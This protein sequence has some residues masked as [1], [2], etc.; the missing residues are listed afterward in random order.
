M[1]R[2]F[3]FA[4][5]KETEVVLNN[6]AGTRR[7]VLHTAVV[8][9]TNPY[10]K[11]IAGYKGMWPKAGNYGVQSTSTQALEAERLGYGNVVIA[12]NTT[13][14][15]YDDAYY[16]AN[17]DKR[18]REN[19]GRRHYR[20]KFARWNIKIRIQIKILWISKGGK[21]TA[22]ISGNILKHKKLYFHLQMENKRHQKYHHFA[23]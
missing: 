2:T 1:V 9:V 16:A 21:H 13:L 8:D 19:K 5:V 15:W 20:H 3:H 4:V 12:T 22:K 7:Q 6:D 10:V 14:S 23:K 18:Y 17:G 11:V